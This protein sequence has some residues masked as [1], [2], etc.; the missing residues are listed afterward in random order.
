MA[1]SQG[2]KMTQLIKT[3]FNTMGLQA[4]IQWKF[5]HMIAVAKLKWPLELMTQN[6]RNCIDSMINLPWVQIQNNFIC[7]TTWDQNQILYESQWVCS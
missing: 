6:K 3:K 1:P 7:E 5:A 4:N 2:H